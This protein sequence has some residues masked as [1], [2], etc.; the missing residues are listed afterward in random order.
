M[1]EESLGKKESLM[2]SPAVSQLIVVAA[3]LVFLPTL[4]VASEKDENSSIRKLVTVSAGQV[5][6][7]D[8]F[9]FG[10]TV[11]ISGT[12]NGDVYAAAGQ[13]LVDGT[14]NGD[15]LAVG[16]TM[17]ISGMVAQDVRVTGGQVTISGEIG[18]NLTVGGGNIELTPS[19]AIHG[20]VVAGGG[21]IQ[22]AAPVSRDVKI[23][24]GNL[25]IS[26]R[27]GGNVGA[28]VGRIRLTS[29]AV[30]T[31]NLTYHSPSFALV[32]DLAKISGVIT[33]KEFPREGLPSAKAILGLLAGLKLLLTVMSFVST[34]IL[35]LLLMHFYPTS[36]QRAVDR[37]RERPMDLLGL[38]LLALIGPPLLAGV[39]ALTIVGLPLALVALAWYF[40]VLYLSR[41]VV[42]A[43]AGQAIFQRLGK[44]DHKRW[45]FMAGLVAYF[46]LAVI[47]VLGGLVTLITTLFGLG[48]ILS[49]KKEVYLAARSQAMI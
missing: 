19:A 47:P 6:D 29:K 1:R 2:N 7:R 8:F 46:L 40:I 10:E 37:L 16:G 44:A 15:L 5:I 9:A 26:N 48:A 32:D 24:A 35:G 25:T 30:V 20:G 36:T 34:L 39:L 21:N 18:R 28:T 12:V 23:A 31:G 11:E 14:I 33:R 38:G 3:L 49:T 4:S 22:L 45:T 17:T 27:I 13:V 41:V 42:I 43:W